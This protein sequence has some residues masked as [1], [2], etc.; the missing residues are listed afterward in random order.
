M[1]KLTVEEQ[2]ILDTFMKEHN[3]TSESKLVR[4][5]SRNYLKNDAGQIY[6]DAKTNPVDMIVDRY[7]GFW[8][9][10]LA[11]EVGQGISFLSQKEDEY[12][13]SDRVC[14]EIQL[15]EVLNQGGLV[16]TVTSLPAYITAYF[17]TLPEGKI[18]VK[19][20]E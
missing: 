3:L 6:L 16:Y 15:K 18:K 14:V 2:Q 9:V 4:Y 1:K 7:H 13:R 10:F 17:C 20:S 5:T 11:S 19:I 8:E 12:E